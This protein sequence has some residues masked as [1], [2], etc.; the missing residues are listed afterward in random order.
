M[1]NFNLLTQEQYTEQLT[2]LA[3]GSVALNTLGSERD[4]MDAVEFDSMKTHAYHDISVNVIIFDVYG[5]MQDWV[6][7][8]PSQMKV[9]Y[10][11]VAFFDSLIN[12]CY[13]TVVT[14][15]WN[16]TFGSDKNPH[17]LFELV[18]ECAMRSK[19]LMTGPLLESVLPSMDTLPDMSAVLT[20]AQ[21]Y[22]L[23]G[24]SV[25]F[26]Y[27]VASTMRYAR[28][29]HGL[30]FDEPVPMIDKPLYKY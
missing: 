2:A 18:Q 17:G 24:T 20:G 22:Y 7:L 6:T 28:K 4:I 12:C 26:Y 8:V 15:I 23:S 1:T 10:S 16:N 5:L 9:D 14:S 30:G 19:R 11:F 25:R 21:M 29:I 3:R 13:E 27:G